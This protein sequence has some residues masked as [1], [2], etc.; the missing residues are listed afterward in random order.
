MSKSV[1]VLCSTPESPE[2]NDT[3]T[4]DMLETILRGEEFDAEFASLETISEDPQNLIL[5]VACTPEIISGFLTDTAVEIL[6]KALTKNGVLIFVGAEE[7]IETL[8]TK[9]YKNHKNTLKIEMIKPEANLETWDRYFK[10]QQTKAGKYLVYIKKATPDPTSAESENDQLKN[11]PAKEPAKDICEKILKKVKE[12]ISKEGAPTKLMNDVVA[13]LKEE[14]IVAT[15]GRKGTAKK[16][17]TNTKNINALGGEEACKEKLRAIKMALQDTVNSAEER[18]KEIRRQAGLEVRANKTAKVSKLSSSSS[19]S[20]SNSAETP[21]ADFFSLFD[22]NDASSRDLATLNEVFRMNLLAPD[23]VYDK[24]A[25]ETAAV[26]KSGAEKTTF[27]VEQGKAI[28]EGIIRK[29]V[30]KGM[31]GTEEE[32]EAAVQAAIQSEA[33][34]SL[35][36]FSKLYAGFEGTCTD[37]KASL[38]CMH[39]SGNNSDCF[40]H[41]FFG[42]TCEFYRMA[43]ATGKSY[44]PFVTRFRKEIVPQIIRFVN[45]RNPLTTMT[46]DELIGELGSPHQFLPDDLYS[47]MA[48]YYNCTI[49]LVRPEAAD[50]IRVAPLIGDNTEATYGISNSAGVHFEPLR[51]VGDKT[52]KL[53]DLQ[54]KCLSYTYS[55]LSG[56][57]SRVDTKRFKEMDKVVPLNK[58]GADGAIA[59]DE[60]AMLAILSDEGE[61]REKDT[62]GDVTKVY[63][64]IRGEGYDETKTAQ[65]RKLQEMIGRLKKNQADRQLFQYEEMAAESQ[66][67]RESVEMLQ[68]GIVDGAK[69]EPDIAA[70]EAEVVAFIARLNPK[71]EAEEKARKAKEERAAK[72]AKAKA[73]KAVAKKG[74]GGRRTLRKERKGR[75]T[76]RA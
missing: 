14:Q 60:A 28:K 48:Y 71:E 68:E 31:Q 1:L 33:E 64:G 17:N 30:L 23:A 19:S 74:K 26:L 59:Y 55:Q 18:V 49:L 27:S 7:M 39:A 13:A 43:K 41:S 32:K 37:M 21:Q 57:T 3:D 58:P 45:E 36:D 24:E 69:G 56:S 16:T 44:T 38:E 22:V 2:Y 35:A 70:K 75:K 61:I 62:P 73:E 8:P 11:K 76:A 10:A 53:S 65:V 50:G 67:L 52:Y 63:M 12:V 6:Y 4:Q 66:D 20:N 9:H 34:K 40:F 29:Q 42:A 5:C 46:V 51:I 47:I 25:V 54:A 15:I 72:A